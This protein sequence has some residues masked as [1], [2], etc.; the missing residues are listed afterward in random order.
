L[1]ASRHFGADQS[2]QDIESRAVLPR[3]VIQYLWVE[4]GDLRELKFCQLFLQEL[5][6]GGRLR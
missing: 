4:L 1:A 5:V 2:R 3:G 6:F